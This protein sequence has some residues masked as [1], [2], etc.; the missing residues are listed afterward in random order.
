MVSEDTL[1][2]ENLESKE[3]IM[4]KMKDIIKEFATIGGVVT[5]KPIG[6][7]IQ[8]SKL[9]KQESMDEEE[10]NV[11][12]SEL[13][14]KLSTFGNYRKT[15]FGENDLREVA[16]GLSELAEYAKQ[17]A[18]TEADENFDKI[19][20]N[21]NMKELTGFSKQFGKI[22][23]EAQQLK[24]RMAVLYEDMGN[25]LGRYFELG[26]AMDPVGKEDG[27]IDNDGDKDD[28]DEYLAKRRKA[29]AK[30]IAARKDK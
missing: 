9:I 7:G 6:N 1:N 20:V 5:E 18:L 23:G 27:D 21:R 22:A 19:T 17:Y 24:E 30:A 11:S 28:S 13:T 2:E 14:E 12:A 8:L 26:E 15:I 25:I 16:K 3:P 29:I 4:V 10:T